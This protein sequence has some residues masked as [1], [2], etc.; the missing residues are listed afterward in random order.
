MPNVRPKQRPGVALDAPVERG[1]PL[2]APGAPALLDNEAVCICCGC[3]DGIACDGCCYWLIVNRRQRV[4][5]CS[6]CKDSKL[7]V[8]ERELIL[9][10]FED[11]RARFLELWPEEYA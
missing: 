11:Q 8:L 10:L 5:I 7:I 2:A 9:E 4:G 3:S 6:Q 1:R